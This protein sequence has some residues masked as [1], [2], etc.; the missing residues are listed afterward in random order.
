[1]LDRKVVEEFILEELK[2]T[3]S[4]IPKSIK[5]DDLFEAFC[6]FTEDLT[7]CLGYFGESSTQ[8][9]TDSLFGA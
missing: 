1:M 9:Q 4:R 3:H 5:R 8:R 2:A 7:L 6:Q